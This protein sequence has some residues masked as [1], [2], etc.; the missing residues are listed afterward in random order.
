MLDY[1]LVELVFGLAN[2][3]K[4]RGPWNKYVLREA[5]R[6]RIP[7]VVRTHVDKMGFLSPFRQLLDG[8]SFDAVFEL[9]TS[10]RAREWG[11]YD[12]ERMIRDLEAHRDGSN[13]EMA[14]RA[15]RVAQLERW[16]SV[17]GL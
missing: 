3:W 7:E 10:R 13:A 1:R 17:H 15:F 2:E 16:A 11:I 5:M 9:V 12:W 4:I 8:K 14:S 6:G